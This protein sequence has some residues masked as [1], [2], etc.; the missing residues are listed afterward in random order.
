MPNPLPP[1]LI[2]ALTT[3]E[4][5]RKYASFV[6]LVRILGECIIT[7]DYSIPDGLSRS[8][9]L[10]PYGDTILTKV[11]TAKSEKIPAK[12]A[13]L[14][15]ALAVG[16]EQ[17][18]IDIDA[19]DV[20]GMARAISDQ[21]VS[22][23]IRFPFPYGR[24]SYDVYADMFEEG[25][26]VLT[27]EETQRFL[28]AT[29]S[30]VNQ[31]GK[32]VTGPYGLLESRSSRQLTAGRRLDAF[33][34]SDPLCDVVHRV[35]LSTSAQA[36]IN[37]MREKFEDVLP[38][39]ETKSVDWFGAADDIR[40]ID[41]IMFSDSAVGAVATLLGDALSLPELRGFVA[42]LMDETGGELR[43]IVS[44]FLRVAD[45]TAAVENLTRAELLQISL[46][47]PES[48]LQQ[49]L[50]ALVNDQKIEIP[51]GDVRRPV[52]NS[53]R[54]SGAFGLSPELGEL[55]VRFVSDHP[56]FA[57]LRL[58]D[59]LTK[60]FDLTDSEQRSDLQ[61]RLRG[62]EAETLEEQLD[63]FFR[64][65]DP[66]ECV[67][68]IGL[69][70]RESMTH[71]AA[72]LKLSHGL[73]AS[74]EQICRRMLWKL[75]F[76]VANEDDPRAEFW[77]LHE[78]LLGLARG[79]SAPGARDTE[80]F[81]GV[82]SKFFRELERFMQ[83]SLAFAAW[84]LLH[85]H[86]TDAHAYRFGLDADNA[87]GLELVQESVEFGGDTRN[88]YDFLSGKLDIYT[89]GRGFEFLSARLASFTEDDAHTRS[90]DDIPAYARGSRLKLFPFKS[91]IPFLWLTHESRERLI[92]GLKGV[93]QALQRGRVS[94][95]RNEHQH[96]RKS[97]A[98]VTQIE[99]ALREVEV[100]MR[101]LESMGFALVESRLE[102]AVHDRWGRSEFY[103]SA[104]RG[105]RHVL[106]RPSSYDWLGLPDLETAQ[107]IVRGAIFAEPNEVLRFQRR[108]DSEFAALWQGIPARR[109]PRGSALS[110]NSVD[111]R[112]SEVRS[113]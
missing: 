89:L 38:Q 39:V 14:M 8:I 57:I 12:E 18:F 13:R 74:D 96:Y 55:G 58:R 104:P 33:H 2:D 111:H 31:Y 92:V 103:F 86:V 70:T 35:H 82:A 108:L 53:E 27:Y 90:E 112:T 9:R 113:S 61:W 17:L 95:V 59:E 73:D 68:R 94:D 65:E 75:G 106:P 72:N 62:I 54:R 36:P 60:L 67:R 83:E 43:A 25:E 64:T 4:L 49:A 80:E 19:T 45:A 107:Y 21:I 52:L 26:P 66:A 99:T 41:A 85:D 81:L 40:D 16:H 102:D 34:C 10:T 109:R 15:C 93:S 110:Q 23:D 7:N 98:G 88:S 87:R 28:D 76:P 56:G 79:S 22:G 51:S 101:S 42:Y 20:D 3:E 6:D 24:E 105:A 97:S 32:Y 5:R 37:S 46:L 48:T 69:A 50:D 63:T 1:E 78:K 91:Q 100:A 29:P 30:G 84:A 77:R 11:V 47:L 44:P 71:L